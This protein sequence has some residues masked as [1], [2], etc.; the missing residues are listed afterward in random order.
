MICASCGADELKPDVRDI[1]QT[2]KGRVN[3]IKDCMP[4]GATI[5]E[6]GN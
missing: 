4:T 1:K 3:I 6:H 2:Y 5:A